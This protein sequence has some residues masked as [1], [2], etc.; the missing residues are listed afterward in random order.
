M[1]DKLLGALI[2]VCITFGP[3]FMTRIAGTVAPQYGGHLVMVGVF[4]LLI[5]LVGIYRILSKQ[6]KVIHDLQARVGMESGQ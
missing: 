3:I 1:I 5:G 6:Q 2:P 4:M